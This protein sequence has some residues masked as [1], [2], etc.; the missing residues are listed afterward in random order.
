MVHDYCPDDYSAIIRASALALVHDTVN[1]VSQHYQC[2]VN[3]SFGSCTHCFLL[4]FLLAICDIGQCLNVQA[5]EIIP[6]AKQKQQQK[7]YVVDFVV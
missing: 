6:H 5:L 7:K 4:L 2:T 1:P 3:K